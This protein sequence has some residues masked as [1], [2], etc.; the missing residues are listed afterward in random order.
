MIKNA[1]SNRKD[2]QTSYFLCQAYQDNLK[3]VSSGNLLE[4][5]HILESS[6]RGKAYDAEELNFRIFPSSLK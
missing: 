3:A 4:A 2:W 5:F 1:K 6:G